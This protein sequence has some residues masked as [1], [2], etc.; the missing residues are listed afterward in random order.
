MFFRDNSKIVLDCFTN[1][2]VAYE[3]F[4][5][6]NTIENL[7]NWWKKL[8]TTFEVQ[9]FGT[10][11][12]KSATIK[13]CPGIFNLFNKGFVVSTPSELSLEIKEEN[14]QYKFNYEFVGPKTNCRIDLHDHRQYM[15]VFNDKFLQGKITLPWLIKETSGVDFTLMEPTWMMENPDNYC[16]PPGVLDF[17][18]QN[19][20]NINFFV[21]FKSSRIDIAAGTPLAHLIPLSD[22]KIKLKHHL[23]SDEEYEKL[24]TLSQ[25]FGWVSS[26]KQR[27]ELINKKSRCPF[28]FL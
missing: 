19:N 17:K 6:S 8:D 28:N 2:S 20:I 16:I 11:R 7:P 23:V 22:K 4:P 9:H 21:E 10:L 18:Y 5:I 1:S 12:N 24:F 13:K 26:Y 15:G 14:N 25:P 3:Y 27:K